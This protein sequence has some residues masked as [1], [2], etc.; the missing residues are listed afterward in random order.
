M[1]VIKDFMM[2]PEIYERAAEDGADSNPEFT[3]GYR[4]AWVLAL[5]DEEVIGVIRVHI[6]TSAM[7]MFHPYIL[8]KYKRMIYEMVKLFFVWFEAHMPTSIVKLNAAFPAN[9][10]GLHKAAL[11]LGFNTQGIDECSYRKGG[12]VLDRVVVGIKRGEMNE[13]YNR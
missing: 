1:S 9:L 7:A 10:T 13:F 4:E 2:T 6:E 12:I 11:R 5:K 3:Y 8:V